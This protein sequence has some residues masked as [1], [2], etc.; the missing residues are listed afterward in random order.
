MAYNLKKHT[1]KPACLFQMDFLTQMKDGKCVQWLAQTLTLFLNIDA[2]RTRKHVARHGYVRHF[3]SCALRLLFLGKIIFISIKLQSA[4]HND[5][6][7]SYI[8]FWNKQIVSLYASSLPLLSYFNFNMSLLSYKLLLL[9]INIT[10]NTASIFH[11]F[12]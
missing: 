4:K 1:G 8:F 2:C 12:W 9:T 7:Q 10:Y 5:L 3:C 11:Y 6:H